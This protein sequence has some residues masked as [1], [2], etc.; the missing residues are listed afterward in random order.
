MSVNLPL[1]TLRFSNTHELARLMGRSLEGGSPTQSLGVC[2]EVAVARGV[3]VVPSISL[4][5]LVVSI[6]VVGSLLFWR[7][8]PRVDCSFLQ[9]VLNHSLPL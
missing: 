2:I 5:F 3:L 7:H 9:S 4:L 1:P 6:C 8:V